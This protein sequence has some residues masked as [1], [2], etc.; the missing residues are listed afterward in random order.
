MSV[1]I[2]RKR[3]MFEHRFVPD[4][5]RIERFHVDQ[6]EGHRARSKR[7]MLSGSSYR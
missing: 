1:R 5:S 7:K 2:I 3:D 4:I 6:R